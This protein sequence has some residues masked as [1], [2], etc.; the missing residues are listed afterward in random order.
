MCHDRE[1]NLSQ[2]KKYVISQIGAIL[3]QPNR[4]IKPKKPS[5]TRWST[6]STTHCDV[7]KEGTT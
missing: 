7:K 6:P 4:I 5:N 1:K 3:S 2:T